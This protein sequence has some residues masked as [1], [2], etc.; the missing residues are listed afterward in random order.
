MVK[1]IRPLK[2]PSN[3]RRR[4]A[5]NARGGCG[6]LLVVSPDV[7]ED[8]EGERLGIR[9]LRGSESDNEVRVLRQRR[10]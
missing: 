5:G 2:P 7:A 6:Q 3:P 4:G 10:H 1:I 8:V 9:R